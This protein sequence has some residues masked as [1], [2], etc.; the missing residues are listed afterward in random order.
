LRHE[1]AAEY[2]DFAQHTR[3]GIGNAR[4]V[5]STLLFAGVFLEQTALATGL[6]A[7]AIAVGGFLTGTR[8]LISSGDSRNLQRSTAAGGVLGVFFGVWVIVID[9]ITS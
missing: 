9:A 8:A 5:T 2:F 3:V 7:A 4:L 6:L 1:D